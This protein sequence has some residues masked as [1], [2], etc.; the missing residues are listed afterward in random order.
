[1]GSVINQNAASKNAA[2]VTRLPRQE[3]KLESMPTV[4]RKKHE[5]V[6]RAESRKGSQAYSSIMP[7]REEP[8]PEKPVGSSERVEYMAISK[9]IASKKEAEF[10]SPT[11]DVT[12]Y[13]KPDPPPQHAT[14]RRVRS[15]SPQYQV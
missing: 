10:I 7:E 1:M 3:E 6:Y 13:Q 9:R 8:V 14:L 12:K 11:V 5:T 15:T 2:T 4:F